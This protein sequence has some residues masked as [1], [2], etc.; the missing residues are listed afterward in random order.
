MRYGVQM[1]RRG[2]L[3]KTDVI[4]TLACD[5]LLSGLRPKPGA[6]AGPHKSR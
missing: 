1:A 5:K 6:K 4:N 2:W 3:E